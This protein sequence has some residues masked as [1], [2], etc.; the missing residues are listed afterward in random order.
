MIKEKGAKAHVKGEL[1]QP[2]SEAAPVV[3]AIG[4]GTVAR[5]VLTI[6]HGDGAMVRGS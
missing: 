5:R 1:A 3:V 2:A 6:E 4:F